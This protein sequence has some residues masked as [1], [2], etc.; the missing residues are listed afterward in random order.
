MAR[1][2]EALQASER[3]F[4]LLAENARDI[5]FHFD[6]YPTPHLSYVSPAVRD[7]LGYT[8]EELMADPDIV[9]QIVS[10][11]EGSQIPELIRR[12]VFDGQLP[13][14]IRLVHKDGRTVWTE[15]R[16]RA[17]Y[18]DQ[19]RLI[20]LEGVARDVTEQKQAQDLLQ[21]YYERLEEMVEERTRELREAYQTLHEHERLG[22]LGELAA[23][24]GRELRN[25][26]SV[27]TNAVY[28]LRLIQPDTDPKVQEYLDIIAGEIQKATH[29]IQRLVELSRAKKVHPQ[30]ISVAS[31][32][33]TVVASFDLPA[34]VQMQ[35]NIPADL[36]PMWVDPQHIDQAL[37]NLIA[38]A[39][40]AMPDG[41]QITI[42]AAQCE[43][44]PQQGSML[45]LQVQDN[46]E[47]IPPEVQARVFEPLYST[48]LHGMG[49]GLALVKNLVEAN[50]GRVTLQSE[51]ERGTT[52]SLY[53]PLGS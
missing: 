3:R 4:R 39:V 6:F 14:P 34:N 33:T 11:D 10:P 19:G 9:L 36:P 26:L 31:I 27:I 37:T 1:E 7:V 23:S 38:N 2:R 50:Q 24:V 32:V 44:D 48:R 46:G 43:E 5:L 47:G 41:G 20:A 42:S 52:V 25:P 17:V 13:Q 30:A 12:R 49:L 29:I 18:D 8:P 15:Q 45:C 21:Q 35:V 40:E 28:Y 22:L 53:L 16:S 51:E